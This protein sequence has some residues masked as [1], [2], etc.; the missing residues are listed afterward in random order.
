MNYHAQLESMGTRFD[1]VLPRLGTSRGDALLLQIDAELQQ[2]EQSLSG[3][4]ADSAVTLL[5]ARL[6]RDHSAAVDDPLLWQALEL[7]DFGYTLTQG[8]FNI[9]GGRLY[10]AYKRNEAVSPAERQAY[11]NARIYLDRATRVVSTQG[12]DTLLD[13]GGLG[14][15]L[16]LDAVKDILEAAGVRNGFVSFGESS[17]LALGH[18]PNGAY[19]SVVVNDP[20]V[21]GKI[22]D[23]FSLRDRF[24]TISSTVANGA[25]SGGLQSHLVDP[26]SGRLI[27]E[28]RTVT[29]VGE[30]G[31]LGEIISTAKLVAGEQ[32]SVASLSASAADS[33]RLFTHNTGMDGSY[34]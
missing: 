24:L 25:G 26:R 22:L 1:L 9:A 29:T 6:A 2:W 4:R 20:L 3:F 16:A 34:A 28:Q 21:R 11:A 30:S 32:L 33:C 18:H 19:W 31:A 12:A 23:T 15:G 27:D 10:A 8:W 7:A 13:F 14:K 17:I 5:N